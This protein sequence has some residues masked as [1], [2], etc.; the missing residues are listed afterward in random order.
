MQFLLTRM[1]KSQDGLVRGGRESVD[2]WTI[3]S[4]HRVPLLSLTV[5]FLSCCLPCS[6]PSF[7]GEMHMVLLYS[8][9][10]CVAFW[11]QGL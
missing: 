8:C 4:G 11:G 3:G 7:P 1:Y 10:S 5:S 6:D 9:N 2:N